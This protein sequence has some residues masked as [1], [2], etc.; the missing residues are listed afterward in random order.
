[1]NEVV[2]VYKQSLNKTTENFKESNP[3]LSPIKQ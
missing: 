1:M 2:A 3:N